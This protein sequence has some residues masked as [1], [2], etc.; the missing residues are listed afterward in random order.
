MYVAVEMLY[1]EG[2][3]IKPMFPPV[4][5]QII[6]DSSAQVPVL[7]LWP[8]GWVHHASWPTPPIAELWHPVLGGVMYESL[9]I[10]GLEAVRKGNTRRWT[11]QKWICEVLSAQRAKSY[12]DDPRIR[13]E[14]PSSV[15][16]SPPPSDPDRPFG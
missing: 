4:V 8:V 3:K 16:P 6:S 1:R 9:V 12:F 7:R 10:R 15:P 5:G 13:G 2:V 14:L 11:T